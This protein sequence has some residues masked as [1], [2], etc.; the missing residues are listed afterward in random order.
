MSA[1]QTGVARKISIKF[2]KNVR[3]TPLCLEYGQYRK[4]ICIKES[5]PHP[6]I[7]IANFNPV[8]L[9]LLIETVRF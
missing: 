7:K 6:Y 3:W 9:I 2:E 4:P 8:Y 5:C 1:R